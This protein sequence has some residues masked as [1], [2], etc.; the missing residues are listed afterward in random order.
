MEELRQEKEYYMK[1]YHRTLDQM[2]NVPNYEISENVRVKVNATSIQAFS[3][4]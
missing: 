2:R 1:E 3:G 4:G